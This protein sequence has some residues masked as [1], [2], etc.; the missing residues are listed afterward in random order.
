MKNPIHGN[1]F[2]LRREEN[3]TRKGTKFDKEGAQSLGA[4]GLQK[5]DMAEGNEE[6]GLQSFILQFREDLRGQNSDGGHVQRRTPALLE[7]I[8]SSCAEKI[9]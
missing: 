6:G 7:K 3:K 5:V 2:S 4:L 1:A 9:V 8:D